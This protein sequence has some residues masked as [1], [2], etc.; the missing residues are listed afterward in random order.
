MRMNLRPAKRQTELN[1]Y[2]YLQGE[3][4]LSLMQQG[5]DTINSKDNRASIEKINNYCDQIKE[6]ILEKSTGLKSIPY[7]FDEQNIFIQDGNLG[8][9][10]F[11][12]G[13]GLQL[14]SELKSTVDLYNKKN[15]SSK[16]NILH[17]A[18]DESYGKIG[19]YNNFAVLNS[20]TQFQMQLYSNKK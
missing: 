18:F 16:I 2:N 13:R 19:Y 5:L 20:I 8:T 14:I 3:Q 12:G 9:E 1:M 10:F 6:M 11:E 7:N 17:S 4:M 15:Q